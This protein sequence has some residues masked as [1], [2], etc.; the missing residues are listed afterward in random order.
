MQKEEIDIKIELCE[1]L[2]LKPVFAVR[3]FPKSWID[4]IR[5]KGG[6]SLIMKYQFYPIG[7]KKLAE[8]VA[9]KLELPVDTPRALED[10]TMKRFI[11]NFHTKNV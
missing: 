5:R 8:E 6:F 7:S 4:E 10:G 3:M 9:Q 1:Y 2:G 11:N